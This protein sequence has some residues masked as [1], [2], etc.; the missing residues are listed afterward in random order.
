VAVFLLAKEND[1]SF[2]GLS[3]HATHGMYPLEIFCEDSEG[4]CGCKVQCMKHAPTG[5]WQDATHLI[6][7]KVDS[8]FSG[9]AGTCS[10]RNDFL[11]DTKRSSC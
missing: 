4:N 2:M 10:K 11:S 5:N 8:R 7:A 6:T 1:G 3:P 9:L